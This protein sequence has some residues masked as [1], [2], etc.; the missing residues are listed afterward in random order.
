[1]DKDVEELI[2]A[3]K[4]MLDKTQRDFEPSCMAAPF[5]EKDKK[6]AIRIRQGVIDIYKQC[7][8]LIAPVD[9]TS[10]YRIVSVIAAAFVSSMRS[11]DDFDGYALIASRLFLGQGKVVSREGME[12]ILQEMQSG[13]AHKKSTEKSDSIN[14]KGADIVKEF[15]NKEK[16]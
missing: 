15:E 5:P 14:G 9:D 16:A 8:D 7:L 4:S 11:L 1:M 3:T 2:V 10:Y 12:L 13:F 6:E